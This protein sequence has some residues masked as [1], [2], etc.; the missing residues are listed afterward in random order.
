MPEAWDNERLFRLIPEAREFAWVGALTPVDLLY[1]IGSIG[2]AIAYGDLF[3]PAF[4]EHDDCVLLR[5]RFEPANFQTWMASTNG[6]RRRVEAVLNHMHITDL[7]GDR[8]ERPTHEQVL[9]L[10]RLLRDMW[11]VKLSHDFPKRSFVVSFPEE[12]RESLQDYE[13]SFYQK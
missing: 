2:Q 1:H 5:E 13:V 4:V 11:A 6:D 8:G 12:E 9:Y 7:F 10:G 3:W